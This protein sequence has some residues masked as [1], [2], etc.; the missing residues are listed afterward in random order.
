M[1]H[2]QPQSGKRRHFSNLAYSGALCA[3]AP[4]A[5][6]SGPEPAPMAPIAPAEAT[7][8]R[9]D[10][11]SADAALVT[12]ERTLT[13][14]IATRRPL[15]ERARR[16]GRFRLTYYHIAAEKPAPRD[17]RRLRDPSC[18]VIAKVPTRFA[19]RLALQGTGRLTDGRIVN[20]TSRCKCGKRCYFVLD[21][22]HPW[23]VG[24]KS[25]PLTPFRS[26]AVDPDVIPIGKALFIPELRGKRMPGLAPWGGYVHDGCV[27]ADDRGGGIDGR[28]LDFF[29][30]RG[31]FYRALTARGRLTR[32][33]VYDGTRICAERKPTTRVARA[34]I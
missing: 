13:A 24:A 30:G 12:R 34:Q 11:N 16:I 29:A 23:G 8:E 2:I 4:M 31:G 27:V 25:R 32:V 20:I 33:T 17:R 1:L 15:P 19:R 7:L 9:T 14:A 18:K 21:D 10:N 3:L 6:G 28:H 22:R 26:V 5:C